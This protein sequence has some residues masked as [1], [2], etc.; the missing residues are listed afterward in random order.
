MNRKRAIWMGILV[1]VLALLAGMSFIFFS[2]Y[3]PDNLITAY[4][5]IV[6]VIIVSAIGAW[7]YFRGKNISPNPEEGFY[8]GLMFFVVGAVLDIVVI[9]I[10]T[11]LGLSTLQ[12]FGSYYTQPSFYVAVVFLILTTTVVGG[13]MRGKKSKP[14]K[15][16]KG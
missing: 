10:S 15:R 13:I 2:F 6:S 16:K 11:S 3:N 1:W 9:I 4:G 8:L 12:D 14:R 7:I 5:G